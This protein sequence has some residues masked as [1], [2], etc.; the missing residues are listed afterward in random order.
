MNLD[1]PVQISLDPTNTA[2]SVELAVPAPTPAKAAQV[3]E[4]STWILL[5]IAAALWLLRVRRRGIP[6]SRAR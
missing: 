5:I 6:R 2:T 3:P 4:S 1:S